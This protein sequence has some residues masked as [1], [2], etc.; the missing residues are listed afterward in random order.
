[1]YHSTFTTSSRAVLILKTH[2]LVLKTLPLQREMLSPVWL[3]LILS[4]GVL[5]LLLRIELHYSLL[6]EPS[7]LD[8]G[9]RI[10]ASGE[11]HASSLSNGVSDLVLYTYYETDEARNNLEFFIEHALHD[12]VDFVFIMNGK[13]TISIP[14]LPNVKVVDRPNEC[15]DL[16]A[17][18]EVL[19][20]NNSF[21]ATKYSRFIMIN[22]SLRGPFFPSWANNCWSDVYL[23]KLSDRVKL[24]GMTYNCAKDQTYPPHLQSMI[25]AT[26]KTGLA[27]I[28]PNLKCFETMH[29]AVFE[30]ETQI[31][32]WVEEA[33]YNVYAMM[34]AFPAYGGALGEDIYAASCTGSDPLFS[35]AYNGSSLH[36]YDTLY[37]VGRLFPHI[38]LQLTGS[39][40][41]SFSKTNRPWN[42]YDRT[43]I[44]QVTKYAKLS[45]YS[46]YKNC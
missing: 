22:A 4:G 43:V 46:S 28:L 12:K 40:S 26:D 35:G 27:A 5:V 8:D 21:L 38:N 2:L 11:A 18:G 41:H 36:P 14:N 23:S 13:Y 30:G 29:S 37:V 45:G 32:R 42:E 31:S 33:G 39:L 17:Y 34:S 10:A 24:V 9:V 25:M 16:G 15:F 6:P 3:A 20:S 19:R 1:M 7:K 44:D